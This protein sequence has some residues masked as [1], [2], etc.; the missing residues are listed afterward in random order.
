MRSAQCDLTADGT[1]RCLKDLRERFA[2]CAIQPSEAIVPFRETAIRAPDMAPPKTPGASR[3]T[4]HGSILSGLVS[5]TIRAV[6]LPEAV[7][8][9]LLANTATT[10]AMLSH[11]SSEDGLSVSD[12]IDELDATDGQRGTGTGGVDRTLSSEQ[13]WKELQRLFQSAGPEWADATE[14]IWAFGPKRIGANLLLDPVGK[15]ALRWVLS[16][17]SLWRRKLIRAA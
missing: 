4:V 10:S 5:F 14:R 2:K 13:F 6:P 9:F 3:G 8:S 15:E 16:A 17:F 7:V 12:D 1:Q 11:R